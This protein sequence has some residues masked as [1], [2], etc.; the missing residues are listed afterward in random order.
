CDA[1]FSYQDQAKRLDIMNDPRIGAFGVLGA[2]VLLLAKLILIYEVLMHYQ[3][4]LT[5]VSI[6]MI[7][8]LSRTLMG[9]MLVAVKPA[10]TKGMGHLFQKAKS[11]RTLWS[12][13][14]YLVPLGLLLAI[15]WKLFV[16]F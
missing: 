15:D 10:K 13:I 12:Y 11:K 6:A 14:I 5:L 4:V 9:W 8:M 16:L 2:I 7:P 3:G 1:F